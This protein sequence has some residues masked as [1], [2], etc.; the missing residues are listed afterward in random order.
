[1][2]TKPPEM[3]RAALAGEDVVIDHSPEFKSNI[4]IGDV[5]MNIKVY[6]SCGQPFEISFNAGRQRFNCPSCAR[7]LTVPQME[8][9][10]PKQQANAE[11]QKLFIRFRNCCDILKSKWET[12][13]FLLGVTAT[14]LGGL[15]VT[16][17]LLTR[18][19]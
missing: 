11:S 1:M 13:L 19:N 17:A 9:K 12:I 10:E 6:C 5:T 7:E 2:T 4:L 14:I 3:Q 18:S 16:L 8:K 15:C